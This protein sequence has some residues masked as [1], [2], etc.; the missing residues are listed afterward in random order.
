MIFSNLVYKTSNVVWVCK[1]LIFFNSSIKKARKVHI[2]F[3]IFRLALI[4]LSHCLCVCSTSDTCVVHTLPPTT[5]GW[6]G[7]C[8]GC[9]T[10]NPPKL[11]LYTHCSQVQKRNGWER[12]L[13]GGFPN[14]CQR[15]HVRYS[16]L[17]AYSCKLLS[18]KMHSPMVS[19]L[20]QLVKIT[21]H[22]KMGLKCSPSGSPNYWNFGMLHQI[23][24]VL[25]I[26]QMFF[27]LAFFKEWLKKF[28]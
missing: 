8:G 14:Q 3:L 20:I 4:L 24:W 1:K 25:F 12:W 2:P 6:L 11:G 22:A 7:A 15:I 28:L 27:L 23:W 18:C 13:C 10:L 19:T 5:T 26:H 9:C 16:Y 21:K 17:R